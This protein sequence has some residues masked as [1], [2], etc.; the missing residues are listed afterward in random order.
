M[1]SFVRPAFFLLGLCLYAN[2]AAGGG[3]DPPAPDDVPFDYVAA[4]VDLGGLRTFFH[5]SAAEQKTA[6]QSAS[7]A[8]LCVELQRLDERGRDRRELL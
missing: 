7:Y 4:G 1:R 5:M 2:Q 6:C 3:F 8:R